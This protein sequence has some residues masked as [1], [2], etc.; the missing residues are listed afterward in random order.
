[1]RNRK[2][3]FAALSTAALLLG[4]RVALGQVGAAQETTWVPFNIGMIPYVDVN[5]HFVRPRNNVSVDGIVGVASGL[6]GVAVSGVAGVVRGPARGLQLAGVSGYVDGDLDGVQLGGVVSAT[7]G[8][9]AGLQL[10]GAVGYAGRLDGAQ[11]GVVNVAGRVRGLQLGIVN[12]AEEVDGAT[13][14]VIN[15]VRKNGR[16]EIEL[17]TSNTAAFFAATKLGTK[18]VYSV[19]GIGLQPVRGKLSWMPTFGLGG[20]IPI[21]ERGFL[22][23]EALASAVNVGAELDRDTI[24][25]QLRLAGGYRVMDGLSFFGGPVLDVLRSRSGKRLSD[26]SYTPTLTTFHDGWVPVDVGLGFAAG[27]QAL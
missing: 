24:L 25:G 23:V 10:S 6:D 4:P 9:V 1:M 11:I 17:S 12:V 26:I 2:T 5:S 14:G 16:H 7:R 22:N 3:V 18:S 20:S 21:E 8:R 13:I 27:V 19:L 15:I